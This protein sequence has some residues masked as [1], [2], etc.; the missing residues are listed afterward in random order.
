MERR[1]KD[2]VADTTT[3]P[4]QPARRNK[5]R[6]QRLPVSQTLANDLVTAGIKMRPEEFLVAW[7]LAVILPVAVF[8]LFDANPITI[9][10]VALIAIAFPLWWMRQKKAKRL[11]RF[12]T[13]LGDALVMAAN[14]LRS[15]LTFQQ[16][17][18][19]IA[20]EMPDPIGLEFSRAI[21]EINLGASVETALGNLSQRI[22]SQDLG[23]AVSAI[24]IQ[25]QVG[26]NLLEL[27]ENIAET[28]Q[29]RNR[30]KND[31]RVMTASGRSSGLIIGILPIAIGG[32]LM[33]IN[34]GYI[35][36]FFET[37]MG[38]TMLIIGIVMETIGFL[39]INKIVTIKY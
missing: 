22:D 33:L 20:K 11:I 30:V 3:T 16:A 39:A 26:G 18:N 29:D 27:L 23:L 38:M 6:R 15:G 36:S 12:E 17:M 9:L 37:Q 7:G 1:L 10:A 25:R 32:I 31:I 28:I 24:Q 34:P 35:E 21:R 14:G 8:V 4:D 5:V 2:F 19:N 13:Q